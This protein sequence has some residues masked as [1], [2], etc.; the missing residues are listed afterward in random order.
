MLKCV[1]ILMPGAARRVCKIIKKNGGMKDMKKRRIACAVL[2][3][4]TALSLAGCGGPATISDPEPDKPVVMADAWKLDKARDGKIKDRTGPGKAGPDAPLGD[5]EDVNGYYFEESLQAYIDGSDS[6]GGGSYMASPASLRA[7]L[8]LAIEG[9]DGDTKSGLLK[10]AGFESEAGMRAWYDGLL[11]SQAEFREHA[12]RLQ[13]DM[14]EMPEEYEEPGDLCMAF[15]IANAVWDNTSFPGG[16][17]E[18]YMDFIS[19]RYGAFA[20]YSPAEDI[21]D[22]VNRWCSENTHGMIEKIS[23]DLSMSSGVLANALYVRSGWLDEFYEGAT[24][25]GDFTLADGGT[26]EMDFMHRTDRYA[27]FKDE[28]GREYAMFGLEGNLWLTVCLDPGVRIQSM[29][30]AQ[31]NSE[32]EK[33]D[34]SMP[35]LDLETTLGADVLNGYLASSGAEAALSDDADFSR[36]TDAPDGWSID[37]VIQRTRLKT[38]EEGMEAAA[39]TAIAMCDNAAPMAPEDPIEFHMDRPFSFLITYDKSTSSSGADVLFFGRYVGK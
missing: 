38:D 3:A 7:A 6:L 31:Y 30:R 28:T 33:L 10:A 1:T 8:C 20:G 11:K 35:K 22:D 25:K 14:A 27:Y 37:Q 29:L 9:A 34:V 24:E 26:Q 17:Q 4:M 5:Q 21:T 13:A 39:V 23:D 16:F 19:E 18:L 12:A 36:M 15:D 32:Y 2:A